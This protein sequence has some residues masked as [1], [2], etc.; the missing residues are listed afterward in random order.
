MNSSEEV[1]LILNKLPGIKVF[2]VV[3]KD[4]II[5]SITLSSESL[6]DLNIESITLSDSKELFEFYFERLSEKQ[7]IFFPPY[8]LFSPRPKDSKELEKKIRDWEKEDDWIA[9]KLVKDKQIIGVCLLKRYKTNRPTSGLAIATRFQKMGL[10]TLLQT[11]INEQCRLLGIKKLIIT[12]AK[13]N[14]ASLKVHE[15]TGFTKT[16]KLVPHFIYQNGVKKIDR[17]DIEMTIFFED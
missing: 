15:K 11:I 14:V 10:G 13:E 1:K 2:E 7:R 9:L 3:I 12:L 4:N 16:G 6:G 8:P 17:Q 5:N